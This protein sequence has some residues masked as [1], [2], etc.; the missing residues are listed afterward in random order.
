MKKSFY[1]FAQIHRGKMHADEFSRFG[2]AVFLD[3]SFPKTS[4]DFDD[5][6]RYI[7]EKAHPHM[8]AA[9]FD[10]LWEEYVRT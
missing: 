2:D 7:E 4:S 6:S 8:T 1:H 5:L 9:V 10:Q 3:H